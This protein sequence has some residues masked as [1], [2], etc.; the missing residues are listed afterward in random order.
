MKI[1]HI[2]VWTKNLE[3]LKKFYEVYFNGIAGEKYLNTKRNFESYFITFEGGGRLEIMTVPDVTYNL[4]DTA[5]QYMGFAHI[6]FSVGSEM[7]VDSLTKELRAAGYEVVSEP[8]RTGDGYYESCILD[9]D[10]NRVEI[11][12]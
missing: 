6:A 11:T 7:K 12:E 2:A 5:K 9:P 1:E 4:A 10:G 3:G 8:R